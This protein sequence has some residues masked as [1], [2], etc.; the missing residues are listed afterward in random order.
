MWGLVTRNL[1][2]NRKLQEALKR[3]NFALSPSVILQRKKTGRQS[4]I[5]SDWHIRQKL[6]KVLVGLHGIA[7]YIVKVW[8]SISFLGGGIIFQ[9]HS[10]PTLL[11]SRPRLGEPLFYWW[12]F[13]QP[14]YRPIPS[15]DITS[16]IT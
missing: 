14:D 3:Q 8:Q 11:R 5:A 9:K 10:G 12:I 13:D 4:C 6:I 2:L 7:F 1:T 16:Y 15:R